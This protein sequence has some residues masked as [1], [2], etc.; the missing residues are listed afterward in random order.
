MTRSQKTTAVEGEEKLYYLP[1]ELADVLRV[2][3][4]GVYAFMKEGLV[5]YVPFG[6]SK[7]I[8]AEEYKRVLREGIVRPRKPRE[9]RK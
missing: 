9:A 7:R 6:A 8:P 4:T 3:R 1:E 5:A 2:S